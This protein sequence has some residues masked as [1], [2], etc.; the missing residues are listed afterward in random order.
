MNG[1]IP[2]N[3]GQLT[4]PPPW[5]PSPASGIHHQR[6]R[7]HRAPTAHPHHPVL[8]PVMSY[9][10]VFFPVS[11]RRYCGVFLT[12]RLSLPPT[13]KQPLCHTA[14]NPG[15]RVSVF[16]VGAGLGVGGYRTVPILYM[17]QPPSSLVNFEACLLGKQEQELTSP[18]CLASLLLQC[19]AKGGWVAEKGHGFNQSCVINLAHIASAPR[20]APRAF[21]RTI[22][23]PSLALPCVL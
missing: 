13:H 18:A 21:A 14:P 4:P 1:A 22:P 2:V 11:C 10:G 9:C 5:P 19:G 3:D 7:R 16:D 23:K 6:R 15:R 17:T 12:F 8:F 20:Y